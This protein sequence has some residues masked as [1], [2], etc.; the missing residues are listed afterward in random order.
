[1]PQRYFVAAELLCL[2]VKAAAPHSGAKVAGRA[3]RTLGDRENIA[4]K[5]IYR[6]IHQ[7]RVVLYKRAVFGVL[8]G[9]HY[10]IL[11]IK[12]YFAVALQLLN[13]FCKQH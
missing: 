12:G 9:V 3:A 7:F 10:N 4:F 1:M 6:Y 8:A 13:A 2:T 11:C 5:N